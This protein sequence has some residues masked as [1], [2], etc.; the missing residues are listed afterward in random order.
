VSNVSSAP[1]QTNSLDTN[2]DDDTD[3]HE[4]EED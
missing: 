3:E 2:E 4:Q 1:C